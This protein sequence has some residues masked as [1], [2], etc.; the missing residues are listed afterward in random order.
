MARL[1]ISRAILTPTKLVQAPGSTVDDSLPLVSWVD[2][3]YAEVICSGNTL[4]TGH[5]GNGSL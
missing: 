4:L 5:Q 2:A 1:V 3:W